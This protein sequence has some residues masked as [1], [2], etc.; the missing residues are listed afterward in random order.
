MPLLA[1][2]Q[3]VIFLYKRDKKPN[4]AVR[5]DADFEVVNHFI[6]QPLNI[7]YCAALVPQAKTLAELLLESKGEQVNALDWCKKLHFGDEDLNISTTILGA[8]HDLKQMS[9][10]GASHDFQQMSRWRLTVEI[11]KLGLVDTKK[12]IRNVPEIPRKE[13]FEMPQRSEIEA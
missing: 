6:L 7:Q 3:T 9:P 12:V 1:P 5:I 13:Q 4:F 2:H 8:S 10:L 11:E